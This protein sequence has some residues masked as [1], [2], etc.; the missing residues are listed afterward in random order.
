MEKTALLIDQNNIVRNVIGA[1]EGDYT[2]PFGW[3]LVDASGN[4]GDTWDGT[5]CTPTPAPSPA[6]PDAVSA[7]Q[8][9]IGC[10]QTGVYDQVKAYIAQ[11]PRAVS[12]AAEFSANFLRNDP[13][14]QAGFA[15]LGKKPAEIDAFFVLC[16]S[17]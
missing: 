9:W 15:A 17:L 6:I 4:M 16:A 5:K 3:M 10:D 7:R 11:Q 2:P 1:P 8:F 13:M 12:L 14:M